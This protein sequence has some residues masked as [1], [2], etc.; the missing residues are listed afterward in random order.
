MGRCFLYLVNYARI[1]PD[2]ALKALPIIQEDM[3]DNNPLVRALALRTMSYVHVRE[4]VEATVPHLKN[5]WW[6]WYALGGRLPQRHRGW[7]L[8]DTTTDT[9][10]NNQI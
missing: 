10:W 6:V 9:W 3:H 8:F 7:V 1:K 2:I 4:F 5:L